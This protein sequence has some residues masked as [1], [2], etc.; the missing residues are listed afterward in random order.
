MSKYHIVLSP[1]AESDLKDIYQYTLHAWGL[2]QAN[3]YI[4]KIELCIIEL[5]KFPK[6]GI[7]RN[8]IK[9]GY[10]SY[11]VEKHIIFY[12][13]KNTS[14]NIY[15]ILHERVDVGNADF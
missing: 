1:K 14:I 3:I 10:R 4:Y 12:E 2:E 7:E 6:V 9:E 8:D 15:G 5:L 11:V 13:I